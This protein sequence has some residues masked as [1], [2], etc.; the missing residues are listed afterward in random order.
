MSGFECVDLEALTAAVGDNQIGNDPRTDT[1]LSSPYLT[2]KDLRAATRSNEKLLN[3]PPPETTEENSLYQAAETSLPRQWSQIREISQE[4]LRDQAKDLEVASWLTEALVRDHD[5]PGLADGLAL[6]REL[7]EK[8]WDEGLFPQEDEDGIETRVAPVVALNGLDGRPSPLLQALKRVPISDGQD[9]DRF[10]L[11]HYDDAL[12]IAQIA[13]G[14]QQQDRL[15]TGGTSMGALDAAL[16]RSDKAFL[17]LNYAAA[18]AC[19]EHFQSILETI[20][21]KSGDMPP[22]TMLTSALDRMINCYDTK[23]SHMLSDPEEG[24]EGAVGGSGESGGGG[25]GDGN[26]ASREDAF[27]SLLRIADYFDKREPQSLVGQSIREVVRRG[28][29][30]VL[31]L[32]E[33]LLP[34]G[35][36]RSSFLMRSGIKVDSGES[37]SY[38]AYTSDE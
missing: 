13:D 31:A 24:E 4:I 1:S 28:R 22:G 9:D 20:Y 23:V 36:L 17:R 35:E 38:S 29:L 33:E 2:L 34:D 15:S 3:G 10:E 5:L 14:Q 32:M 27:R 19:R 37:S 7:V 30:P 16:Q 12:E 25:G 8:Y 26:M 11:W 18:K 6:M 21:T